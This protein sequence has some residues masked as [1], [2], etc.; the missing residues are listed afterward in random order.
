MYIPGAPLDPPL[1][2]HLSTSNLK[3]INTIVICTLSCYL[4]S[5]S[6]VYIFKY[7]IYINLLILHVKQVVPSLWTRLEKVCYRNAL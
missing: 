1:N 3:S 2:L 6:L 5:I 4:V 7:N